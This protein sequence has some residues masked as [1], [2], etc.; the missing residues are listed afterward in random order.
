MNP[1]LHSD[2]SKYAQYLLLQISLIEKRIQKG[3][4]LDADE[5]NRYYNFLVEL[6]R[7]TQPTMETVFKFQNGYFYA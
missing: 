3:K 7:L 2:E 5:N 4:E 6:C 1:Y